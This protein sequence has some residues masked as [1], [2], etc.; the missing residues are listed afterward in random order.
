MQEKNLERIRGVGG[1]N[2]NP[3]SNSGSYLKNPNKGKA[4]ADRII[5]PNTNDGVKPTRS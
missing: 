4:L 3:N 2:S 5:K 1:S